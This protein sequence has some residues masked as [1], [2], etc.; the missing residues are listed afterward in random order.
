MRG[1]V[2][3]YDSISYDDLIIAFFPCIFFCENNQLYFTGNHKNLNKLSKKE[4]IDT[5]LKRSHD[6][7][8]FYQ[9]ALKMFSVC[10]IKGLRMIVE[11]PYATQHF[12]V[13]NFPYKATFVDRNRTSRGDFFN[14]PTQYWF[15]NC[16]PTYGRSYQQPK[17]HK[18]VLKSKSSSRAGLARKN[19]R[20]SVRTMRGISFAVSSLVGCRSIL[21][22]ICLV[23]S[24]LV[25]PYH[26]FGFIRAVLEDMPFTC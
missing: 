21:R 3:I 14:K 9:L 25:P 4:K 8:Y 26:R 13:G 7:E 17:E 15:V 2:S 20:L 23:D 12:L 1:G 18:T 10:D 16:E 5:I 6:R 24:R 11:N 22:W 19:A